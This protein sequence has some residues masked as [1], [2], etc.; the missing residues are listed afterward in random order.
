[1]ANKTKKNK[2]K[3]MFEIKCGTTFS[4]PTI[5]LPIQTKIEARN[6]S[7]FSYKNTLEKILK[8]GSDSLTQNNFVGTCCR[9]YSIKLI[10]NQIIPINF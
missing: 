3:Q 6:S 1:M 4:L 7:S 9:L 8:I 2:T 5:A 10:K